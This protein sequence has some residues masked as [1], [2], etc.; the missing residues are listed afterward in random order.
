MLL[1]ARYA[2]S[3]AKN[4]MII[5]TIRSF[6]LPAPLCNSYNETFAKPEHNARYGIVARDLSPGETESQVDASW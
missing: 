3:A 5:R 1:L 4:R 6:S 2:R